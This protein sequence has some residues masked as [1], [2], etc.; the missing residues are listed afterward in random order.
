MK[1]TFA[2]FRCK[3]KCFCWNPQ[4]LSYIGNFLLSNVMSRRIMLM[5]LGWTLRNEAMSCKSRCST[6]PGQRSIN[7]S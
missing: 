6:M 5:V 3:D 1:L 4:I 7:K 2:S